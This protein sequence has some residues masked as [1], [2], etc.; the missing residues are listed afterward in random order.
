MFKD[1][2]GNNV[3]LYMVHVGYSV[4]QIN[5]TRLTNK[6]KTWILFFILFTLQRFFI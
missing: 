2:G 1:P 4:D 3:K 6:K 5:V